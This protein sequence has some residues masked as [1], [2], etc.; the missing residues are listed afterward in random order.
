[1][2]SMI[3]CI[4]ICQTTFMK[5]VLIVCLKTI[6]GNKRE[7]GSWQKIN[8]VK[9]C[10]FYLNNFL[11]NVYL[12]RSRRN[13]WEEDFI[14]I[15]LLLIGSVNDKFVSAVNEHQNL[16]FMNGHLPESLHDSK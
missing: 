16:M 1:M 8:H 6:S 4:N 11:Y 5:M 3:W 2:G 10:S 7:T 12:T 15:L 13:Q 9:I 14:V